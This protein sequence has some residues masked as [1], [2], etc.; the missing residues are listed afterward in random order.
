LGRENYNISRLNVRLLTYSL[1]TQ[2]Q[3]AINGAVTYILLHELGH[4]QL[5]HLNNIPQESDSN[6]PVV[7]NENIDAYKQQEI[8]ADR[9]AMDSVKDEAK[10]VG[11]FWQQQSMTFFTSLELVSGLQLNQAHLMSINRSYNSDRLR[12]E[13]GQEH[14]VTSRKQLYETLAKRFQGT[15]TEKTEKV[16]ALVN[17]SNEGCWNIVSQL[18]KIYFSHGLDITKLRTK[19]PAS[20]LTINER[21]MQSSS[22]QPD[23]E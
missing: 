23:M 19:P 6:Q 9:Y 21:M 2:S 15:A 5:G 17:T 1:V 22:N 11:T 7:I 8:E 3:I 4:H 13:W 16:N 14:G 12:D 20:W 10:V 18:E